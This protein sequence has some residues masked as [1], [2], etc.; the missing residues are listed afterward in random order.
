MKVLIAAVTLGDQYQQRPKDTSSGVPYRIPCSPKADSKP[1]ILLLLI[2]SV[3]RHIAKNHFMFLNKE[4]KLTKILS[5]KYLHPLKSIG[6]WQLFQL[7]LEVTAVFILVC[8]LFTYQKQG[9]G[10]PVVSCLCKQ[11]AFL[12]QWLFKHWNS[13]MLCNRIGASL[14]HCFS[15]DDYSPNLPFP[16]QI[17]CYYTLLV[18]D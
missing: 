3:G 16:P 13:V 8:Q 2:F 9:T 1:T 12:W 15:E 11:S 14:M 4:G 7:D 18:N 5:W 10:C 17:C 6:L